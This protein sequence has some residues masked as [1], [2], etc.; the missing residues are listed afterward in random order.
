M[1][2]LLFPR[3]TSPQFLSAGKFIAG[4]HSI[5]PRRTLDN[6]VLLI[7]CSGTNPIAQDGRLYHLTAD[8]FMLLPAGH[9]HYGIAPASHKQ[10]HFWCHFLLPTSAGETDCF[11]LPEF[12]RLI[13]A[14]K[15]RILFTQLIDTAYDSSIHDEQLRREVCNSYIRIILLNLANELSMPEPG[16]YTASKKRQATVS[17]VREWIRLHQSDGITASQAA[18]ACGYNRDYLT[19][20]FQ[21]ELHCSINQYIRTQRMDSA[22]KLLL[23]TDLSIKEIAREIGFQDEKYFMKCFK[24]AESV[25]PSEYRSTYFHVHINHK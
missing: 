20:M 18:E 24:K 4:E 7:G 2:E 21:A 3:H 23:N 8:H 11:H 19:Q 13:N 5:H 12:G 14:E 17:S 16:K 10:S 9:T 1:F 6:H 15:F 25:T 22:K